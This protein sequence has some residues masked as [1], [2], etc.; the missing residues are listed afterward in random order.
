MAKMDIISAFC[1]ILV[2][3]A[4][5]HL[6][7]MKWREHTFIDTCLPFDLRSATKLFNVLADLPAG[8]LTR[9]GVTFVLHYLDDFLT[10][11]SPAFNICLHNSSITQKVCISF[12]I[13]LALKKVEGLS[14]S[15]TFLGITLDTTNMEGRL[16][17]EKLTRIRQLIT[18]WLNR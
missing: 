4:D 6:L 15:L 3:P 16:P 5:R 12:G 18:S 2:H 10:L 1:L 14:T 8:V 9:L 17:E 11:G 13:P 7:G